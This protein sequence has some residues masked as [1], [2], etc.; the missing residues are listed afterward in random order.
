MEHICETEH[1]FLE[2]NFCARTFSF[3]SLDF[4]RLNLATG[5]ASRPLPEPDRYFFREP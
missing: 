5:T 3:G 1:G 2:R 4:R